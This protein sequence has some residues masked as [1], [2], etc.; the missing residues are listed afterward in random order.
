Y[1]EAAGPKFLMGAVARV[2]APG[3]QMDTILVLE[4]D[5]GL[6][7]STAVQFL[8]GHEWVRDITGELHTKDAALNIQGVW[9]GEMAE[10]ASIRKSDQEIIK[11]FISRR[12]DH[13]RPPYGRNSVDRPRHTVFI[14]TTNESEYLQDPAGARRFWPVECTRIDL[15]G[16]E[17]DR[18]Q[19][20]PEAVGLYRARKPWHLRA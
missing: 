10:L 7:K 14:A 18:D 9:I 3:C 1:F 4:G 5:Q 20:R 15:V 8:G 6:G 12:I 17:R 2:F 11:G 19:L 13:Y 16:L